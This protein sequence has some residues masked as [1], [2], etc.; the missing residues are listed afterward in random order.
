MPA[1]FF[2]RR[3]QSDPP[4][5]LHKNGSAKSE[6]PFSPAIAVQEKSVVQLVRDRREGKP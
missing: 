6:H 4:E 5:K 1:E 3:F 2:A